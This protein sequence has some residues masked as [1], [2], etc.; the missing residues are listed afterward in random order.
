[1]TV[2]TFRAALSSR[3]GEVLTPELAAWLEAHAFDHY[4]RSY[5]PAQFAPKTYR[6]LTFQV[7]RFADVESEIHG[8]HEEHY[9]ETEGHRHGLTMNPNYEAFKASERAGG[10]IQF[11]ARCDGVLVGNIRM[12]VYRSL[13]TQ[14]LAAKEDTFFLKPAHRQ[15]FAAIRFWQYMECA[16]QQ[17]GVLEITTDSKQVN[18]VG[19]LNDC[20]LYTSPS[21]RD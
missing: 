5:A 20:L 2:A 14:T 1:M 11:T 21:P 13:H 4:D 10:L 12:Y 19:R 16:L 8:L 6:G 17:I 3:L 7:E 9:R 18:Q 15:G